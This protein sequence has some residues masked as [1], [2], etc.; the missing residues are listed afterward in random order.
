MSAANIRLAPT[1]SSAKS[2][3]VS[4][5]I[6]IEGKQDGSATIEAGCSNREATG[7]VRPTGDHSGAGSCK[8]VG[9][10]ALESKETAVNAKRT[11]SL[12]MDG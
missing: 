5:S 3:D 2:V 9:E 8:I 11:C 10:F 1:V 7:A 12:Y 6:T 4:R